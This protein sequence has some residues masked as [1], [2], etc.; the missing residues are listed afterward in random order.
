MSNEHHQLIHAE[1]APEEVFYVPYLHGFTQSHDY[2]QRY[3][4]RSKIRN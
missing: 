4:G 2:N 1:A 3:I